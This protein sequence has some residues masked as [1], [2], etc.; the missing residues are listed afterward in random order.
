M[1]I[2]TNDLAQATDSAQ[3]LAP[4]NNLG[5]IQGLRDLASF[6]EARPTFGKINPFRIYHCVLDKADLTH[7]LRIMG[8]CSKEWDDTWLT[9]VKE[10]GPKNSIHVTLQTY[11]NRRQ[12]CERRTTSVEVPEVTIP[13][14]PAQ[15]E[16]TIA[17]HFEERVEWECPEDLSL[18]KVGEPEKGGL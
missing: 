16:Q 1:T 15:P 6:L 13:G 8:T 2:A 18:L 5:L 9:L 12:I 3:I 11:I 14:K 7:D 4:N 10:F 17:A